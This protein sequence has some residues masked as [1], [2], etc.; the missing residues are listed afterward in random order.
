MDHPQKTPHGDGRGPRLPARIQLAGRT[1]D[2]GA[3]RD[4]PVSYARLFERARSEVGHALCLC[5]PTWRL[6]LVIRATRSGRYHVAGWPGEG[7]QHL[8]R[9]PFHK[10]APSLTGRSGYAS[11]AIKESGVGTSIRFAAPLRR[12]LEAPTPGRA[13][14]A[15]EA[16]AGPSRRAVGLLGL[17]HWLWEEARL[18][19]WEPG[20]SVTWRDCH[21]GLEMQ[22][23]TCSINGQPAASALHIVPPF[24][25]ENAVRN[26]T[27]LAA[28]EER[29]GRRGSSE[30]RGLILGEARA[31][32]P[33]QFGVRISLAH[34]RR[35][36]FAS[37]ALAERVRRSHPHVFSDAAGPSARRIAL[38]L[39]D[40][41]PKGYL[42]V[43]N[44][45]LM[46]T[47]G[48]Y[49]PADS[50]Y[51]VRMA[52]HLIAAR[53]PFTKPLRYDAA[54]ED[55]FPDFVLRDTDPATYVEVYGVRG[56][57]E[58]ERRKRVKQR[59]YRDHGI[60]V[61]EWDVAAK[62]PDVQSPGPRRSGSLR[63]AS[64]SPRTP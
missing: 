42:T 29:L 32:E 60:P 17:L 49:I 4:N 24:R 2:L 31:V 34:Q 44:M 41:H 46:L 19:S 59:Y 61:I 50:S 21:A 37:A 11:E 27:E 28:F 14:R 48:S 51:E 5:R 55:V 1:V 10:I 38:A 58:Y 18:T 43:S 15:S 6:R 8:A 36:L 12:Q 54:N 3:V 7:D 23:D 52:D 40:R 47:N 25:P 30:Y 39:V 64:A 20:E 53:R 22:V 57:E 35:P 56:R 62:I 9:C 45:A 13:P 63:T 16:P 33:T 26:E